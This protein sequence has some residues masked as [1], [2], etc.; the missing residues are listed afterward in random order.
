[1]ERHLTVTGFVVHEGR[2]GMHWHRK[3]GM[4]LP[5]GGHIEAD[6]DPVQAVLREIQEEFHIE[7][8]VLPLARRVPY[9]GGPT[10][11]EPPYT[12]LVEDLTD[13]PHQHID[14]IYFCRL[15]SG[16]PGTSYDADNPILWFDL[17]ALQAGAA[18]RDGELVAFAPDVQALA[19]EAIRQAATAGSLAAT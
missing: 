15:L 2:V 10:Q 6:E 18:E 16:Y 4:W 19:I 14:L 7:A 8:D 5:A 11:L 3:V 9:A 1:M 13:P 17:E 12:I